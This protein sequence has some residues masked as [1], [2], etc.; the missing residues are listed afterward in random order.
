MSDAQRQQLGLQRLPETLESALAALDAD[1]VVRSWFDPLF[2]ES[3]AGVRK[4]EM[5]ALAGLEPAAICEKYR[6]LY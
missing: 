3:F 2:L 4:A 6:T 1:T 5:Q